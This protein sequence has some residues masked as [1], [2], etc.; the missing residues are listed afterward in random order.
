MMRKWRE[1]DLRKCE[2]DR[3]E[4]DLAIEQMGSILAGRPPQ[5][6]GA[7]L[8]DLFSMWLASWHP[9]VRDEAMALLLNLARD[10]VPVQEKRA[11]RSEA[12][13]Q[14]SETQGA[15]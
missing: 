3:K 11:S 9:T 13:Q 1:I 2:D 4:C 7:I 8:A 10:R 12:R 14:Q 5:V 15:L 6:Q